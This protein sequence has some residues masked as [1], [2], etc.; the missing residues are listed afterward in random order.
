MQFQQPRERASA[1]PLI[2][3][4]PI[5]PPVNETLA[6]W[7][8]DPNL[9]TMTLASHFERPPSSLS[10]SWALLSS[11]D[12][13]SEDDTRSELTD[14]AS[15]TGT[16]GI[17]DVSSLDDP[18]TSSEADGKDSTKSGSD[19]EESAPFGLSSR[20]TVTR[21]GV[22]TSSIAPGVYSIG[23]EAIEFEEPDRWP[24]AEQV[25]LKHII[26]IF[27]EEEAAEISRQ[28][29]IEMSNQ[30]LVAAVCQTMTK[31]SLQLDK[32]FR[33][34]YAGNPEARHV[35]LDKIGD[36]LVAGTESNFETKPGDSSRYH[37]V[38]T[39]FGNGDMPNFAELL[40]IHVQLVVDECTSASSV[41]VEKHADMIT[42]SFKNRPPCH[43]RLMPQ[44]TEYQI[45]SAT[46]WVLPDVA[47]LFMSDKD[48]LIARRTRRFVHA[49]AKRHG[50]PV[51]IVSEEPLWGRPSESIS[52]N[53]QSLHLCLESRGS[54]DKES[55]VLKRLPI[56]LKTFESVAPGQI[57]R[58]LACLTDSYY[59][60]TIKPPTASP[61]TAKPPI[62]KSSQDIENSPLTTFGLAGSIESLRK[63]R[64]DIRSMLPLGIVLFFWLLYAF[65]SIG[66][67]FLLQNSSSVAPKMDLMNETAPK[68]TV[69]MTTPSTQSSSGHHLASVLPNS[70]SAVDPKVDLAQL[71]I[72]PK[73][74]QINDSD[75]FEIHVLGDCHIVLKPPR[76]IAAV[77][78]APK[79]SVQVTK[80]N[81]TVKHQVSKLFDGVYTIRLEREDAYGLV[82]VSIRTRTKPIVSQVSEVDFG[83]PWLKMAGWRRAAQ[84][85]S[86]QLRKDLSS[87]QTSLGIAYGR[88][89]TD[90][91]VVA[92]HASKKAAILSKEAQ[93]VGEMSREMAVKQADVMLTKSR[94][95][96]LLAAERG[97]MA[98]TRLSQQMK[99]ATKAL[100][101]HGLALSK[102]LGT[103]A[104]ES[105]KVAL[106]QAAKLRK[107]ASNVNLSDIRDKFEAGGTNPLSKAQDRAHQLWKHPSACKAPDHLT[108]KAHKNTQKGACGS[109]CNR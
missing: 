45:E 29:P 37:V 25:E 62:P 10:E 41:K 93:V 102:E 86:Q 54:A 9:P 4:Y 13:A 107:A 48:D 90:L 17:D 16:N 101:L 103:L 73:M 64:P 20:Q 94:E 60:K 46:S 6:L 74:N 30:Q 47:I 63:G 98:S 36:A 85:A 27:D 42:L 40:P 8:S 69:A 67:P 43:S 22:T 53:L 39:S 31:G 19:E 32:P 65:A 68:S 84:I 97:A 14:L 79:F 1:Q 91:H 44:N 77:K 15:V 21:G 49:F 52:L 55:R 12:T 23:L 71:L 75:L 3:R 106:Q 104:E 7:L 5:L 105:W 108:K 38:P 18:E 100:S 66:L 89:R 99:V 56:D 72:D 2:L 34:L 80:K 83:H 51:M 109:R 28:M 59:G 87:A 35:I 92:G 26:R 11:S 96:S 24:D 78:K 33:V 70:V 81:E 57:N 95:L 50:I 61:S 88:L 82:N 76:R 58:N